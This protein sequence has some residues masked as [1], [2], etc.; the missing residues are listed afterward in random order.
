[1]YIEVKAYMFLG[2]SRLRLKEENM[3]YHEYVK[4]F[5]QALLKL[6]PDYRYKD[7]CADSR[8]VLLKRK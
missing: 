3:P 8:I 2:Y 7:E 4:E 1:M 5:S 6:L